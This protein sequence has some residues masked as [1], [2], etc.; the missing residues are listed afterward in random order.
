MKQTVVF[1]GTIFG[2]GQRVA[3]SGLSVR[4]TPQLIT[5]I[6]VIG[7]DVDAE[8]TVRHQLQLGSLF[9]VHFVRLGSSVHCTIL[10]QLYPEFYPKLPQNSTTLANRGHPKSLKN[11]ENGG[12][13][14]NSESGV[15]PI[16]RPPNSCV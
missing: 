12:S 2:E 8:R 15:L 5:C 14:L 10:V 11:I 16:G 1:I 7:H 6:N 4:C 9:R 13:L 3:R